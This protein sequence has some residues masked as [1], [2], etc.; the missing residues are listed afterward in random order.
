MFFVLLMWFLLDNIT[1]AI[2]LKKCIHMLKEKES[3]LKQYTNYTEKNKQQDFENL[4][5][6]SIEK[7][8]AKVSLSL[9]DKNDDDSN[10]ERDYLPVMI[11]AHHWVILS[12]KSRRMYYIQKMKLLSRVI[13][14]LSYNALKKPK[15][16]QSKK[17]EPPQYSQSFTTL[18]S[19]RIKKMKIAMKRS[20]SF[21]P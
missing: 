15:L 14:T 8:E 13:S 17:I 12:E 1:L 5:L 3:M 10:E 7:E 11:A 19:L 6:I 9:P 18:D 21:S 2:D 4:S 16:N 20:Q